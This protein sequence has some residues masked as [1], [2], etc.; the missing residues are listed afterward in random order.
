MV[1]ADDCGGRATVI[2]IIIVTVASTNQET[3]LFAF[4]WGP[5]LRFAWVHIRCR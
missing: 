3:R 5:P 4:T 1:S 2:V